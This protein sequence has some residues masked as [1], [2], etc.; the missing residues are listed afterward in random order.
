VVSEVI[1]TVPIWRP[2]LFFDSRLGRDILLRELVAK[3][4]APSFHGHQ[5][6]QSRFPGL[7]LFG[8]RHAGISPVTRTDGLDSISLALTADWR[9]EALSYLDGWMRCEFSVASIDVEL[10]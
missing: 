2:H 8:T 9:L 10:I 3:S 4:N 1:R 5:R 7:L 6:E